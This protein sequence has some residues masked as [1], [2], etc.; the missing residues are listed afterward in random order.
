MIVKTTQRKYLVEDLLGSRARV[1]ILK[2]LAINEE[3]TISLIIKKTKLNYVSVSKHLDYLKIYDLVQ[4]KKFGRIKIF[5]F[6]LEN[7]K[8][9][10][11][12]KFIEI[13]EGDF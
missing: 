12:K 7:I 2:S 1:K 13:W 8:A 11:L 9:R 6:K 5:R 4:E 10:S 3:L